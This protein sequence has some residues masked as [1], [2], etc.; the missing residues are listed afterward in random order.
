MSKVL[1]VLWETF[2]PSLHNF[3]ILAL[4]LATT[5]LGALL[6]ATGWQSA[7][8]SASTYATLRL[9]EDIAAKRRD[10]PTSADIRRARFV[11]DVCGWHKVAKVD[12]TFV[13]LARG[14]GTHHTFDRIQHDDVLEARR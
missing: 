13:N 4:V 10:A 3:R 11:R 9:T 7:L 6:N 12:D 2:G 5:T 8:F 1:E 14:V